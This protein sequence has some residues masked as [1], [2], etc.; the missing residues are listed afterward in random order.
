VDE[1]NKYK[2]YLAPASM[3]DIEMI[4]DVILNRTFRFIRYRQEHKAMI[5][6]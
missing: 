5:L 6:L 4:R 1:S 3:H 2:K